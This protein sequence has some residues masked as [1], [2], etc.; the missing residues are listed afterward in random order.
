MIRPRSQV[1]N[2]PVSA[3]S[4]SPRAVHNNLRPG[5]HMTRRR[6]ANP[7]GHKDSEARGPEAGP[8]GETQVAVATSS[9]VSLATVGYW[10]RKAKG[11]SSA[12]A[13]GA[14]PPQGKAR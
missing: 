8:G 5:R 6:G 7:E 2:H 1:Q 12:A 4:S 3:V 13:N 11:S 14:A 10:T 9:G